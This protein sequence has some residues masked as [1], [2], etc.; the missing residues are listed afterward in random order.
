MTPRGSLGP[1]VPINSGGSSNHSDQHVLPTSLSN[2]ALRYPRGLLRTAQTTD[3][4][5]SFGVNSGNR[6]Q[7]RPK[8]QQD[9]GCRNGPWWKP[10]TG[11]HHGLLISAQ[12]SLPWSLHVPRSPQCTVPLAL[13]SLPSLHL[14]HHLFHV[15]ITYSSTIHCSDIHGRHLSVTLQGLELALSVFHGASQQ[16][17][18][19]VWISFLTFF[20]SCFSHLFPTTNLVT[21]AK[22]N[23]CKHY[24]FSIYLLFSYYH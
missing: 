18:W 21:L 20:G 16:M 19:G 11:P 24:V 17:W 14:A 13:L 6:H 8:L 1:D 3:I 12:S 9:H 15:P 22:S 4:D 10:Q 5:L 7:H 2:T 23:F